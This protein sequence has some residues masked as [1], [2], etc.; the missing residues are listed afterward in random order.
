MFGFN[1][2]WNKEDTLAEK[3]L[4]NDEYIKERKEREKKELER[5]AEIIR[6]ANKEYAYIICKRMTIKNEKITNFYDIELISNL[7]ING[8]QQHETYTRKQRFQVD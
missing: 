6:K 4:Y 3:N 5:Q 7:S 2:F 1:S 8:K